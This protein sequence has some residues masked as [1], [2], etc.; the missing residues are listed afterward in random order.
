[1]EVRRS[2]LW[3]PDRLHSFKWKSIKSFN[4][5]SAKTGILIKY[6][7]F[8]GSVKPAVFD[9]HILIVYGLLRSQ[10]VICP[11]IHFRGIQS[12]EN[13]TYTIHTPLPQSRRLN[14]ESQVIIWQV[15]FAVN[16]RFHELA[17]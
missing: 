7:T 9:V 4:S 17:T 2:G 11:Y 5:A 13:A 3:A 1:M 6:L 10:P 15:I 12:L 14:Y 16:T 8:S